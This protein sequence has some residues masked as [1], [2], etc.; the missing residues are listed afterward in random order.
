MRSLAF[1]SVT[2][3]DFASFHRFTT[4]RYASHAPR[5]SPVF[6]SASP[7]QAWARMCGAEDIT[8]SARQR[9]AGA[10]TE[11][12]GGRRGRVTNAASALASKPTVSR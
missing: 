3:R 4:G 11:G 2:E 12:G 1:V 5:G 10:Q 6:S 8:A 9:H 7:S